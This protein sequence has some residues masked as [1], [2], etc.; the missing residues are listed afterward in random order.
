[1]AY[2]DI[3]IAWCMSEITLSIV[4]LLKMTPGPPFTN[5]V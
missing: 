1:M 2:V 5:M 3:F 4:K